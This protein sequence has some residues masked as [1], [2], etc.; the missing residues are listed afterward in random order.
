ADTGFFPEHGFHEKSEAQHQEDAW[1]E[2]ACH[3]EGEN[4]GEEETPLEDDECLQGDEVEEE[5]EADE[6]MALE[7]CLREFDD[8]EGSQ[9]A[10]ELV[11]H[12]KGRK[13]AASETAGALKDRKPLTDMPHVA[14]DLK[15]Q[16]DASLKRLKA[17][18]PEDPDLLE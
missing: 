17:L 16:A 12:E 2:G 14:E 8:P 3:G 6:A 1:W 13:P 15:A 18:E 9:S 5:G 4:A 7:E 11:D 10:G